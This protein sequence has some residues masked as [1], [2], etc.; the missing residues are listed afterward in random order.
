[1]GRCRVGDSGGWSDSS[2][3][4]TSLQVVAGEMTHYAFR[5]EVGHALFLFQSHISICGSSSHTSIR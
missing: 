3:T 4:D 2:S 5:F 1:M